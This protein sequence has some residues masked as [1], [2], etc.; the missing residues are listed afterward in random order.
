MTENAFLRPDAGAQRVL[1]LSAAS[2]EPPFETGSAQA[3]RTAYDRGNPTLQGEKLPVR[4]VNDIEVDGGDGPIKARLY[5]GTAAPAEKAPL[6]LYLH[7]G[8][9]VIGN[10]DSHDDICRLF[11]ERAGAVV[12]CPD[13]RLAPEHKFPAAIN[14]CVAVLRWVHQHADDLG[15]DA[16]NIAVAGDSAGGN[17]AS[18]L[19]LLARDLPVPPLVAQL[20]IYPNTD[21]RQGSDSY[22]RFGEGFGLTAT[23]MRWFRDHYVRN[24]ADI[25]DWRVSPLLAPDLTGVAPAFV[26]I[27]GLDILADEGEAYIERLREANVPLSV[28]RWPDQIHGFASMGRYIDAARDVVEEAVATWRHFTGSAKT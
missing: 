27:A 1:D 3:A 16:D 4:A 13:Y 6:L 22:R 24:E 2:T 10:L 25:V 9:W 26:A 7:G 21:A 12:L 14:D 8:G 17:L 5:R 11:A 28:K 20:L 23:T 15:I 18:V 19:A